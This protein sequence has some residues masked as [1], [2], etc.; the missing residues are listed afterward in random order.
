MNIAVY[1]PQGEIDTGLRKRLAML[2]KIRYTPS[3]EILGQA[4]LN[5]HARDADII[6]ADPDN[7]G[8]FEMAKERLTSVLRENPQVR[9]VAL[10]TTSYGW[11]DVA[12]CRTH[13]I[14]VS[15]VPGYSRES[16]AEHTLGLLL[17]LA[18]RIIVIDRKTRENRYGLEMGFELAGKTLGIIGLGSIG[19]RVAQLGQ[20][21]GMDVIAYNPSPR[22][23]EGVQMVSMAD[24]LRRSQAISIHARDSIQ[25]HHMVSKPELS[26]MKRGVIIVNTAGRETVDEADMAHALRTGLVGG[27][28][29]EAEDLEHTPLARI[30]TAVGLKGFGWYTHEALLNLYRIA[31]ENIETYAQGKPQNTVS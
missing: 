19:S 23:Q 30:D 2:G 6:A 15:N 31:V 24:L 3:R 20:A 8:G 25:T 16:V 9:H 14:T 29:Y 7:F 21:I 4:Q 13:A 18:K 12:F 5:R 28:A 22:H 11:I 1:L 10:M 26:M 27:Y 17:C